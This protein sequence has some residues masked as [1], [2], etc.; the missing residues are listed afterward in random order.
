V[1]VCRLDGW[2][3]AAARD[4]AFETVTALRRGDGSPFAAR[5]VLRRLDDGF[6]GRAFALPDLTPEKAMPAI[7][8]GGRV[9]AAMSVTRAPFLT[10]TL[11]PVA[12]G[13]AWSWARG[14]ARPFPLAI[15]VAAAT[16]AALL[17]VA[18]NMLND[19][20]DWQSGADK[21]N[22]EFFAPFSGGSRSIELGLLSARGVLISGLSA[23]GIASII[24]IVLAI[25]RGWGLVAFGAVGAFA[26]WAYT[27]PPLR[28]VARRGL[29]ELVVGVCF[30]PMLVAGT[31]FA[32]T[33]V[34]DIAAFA[35]GI[36]LGLLTLAILWINEI[37][38][39]P[40]DLAAGKTNLVVVLG[41]KRA[42][43]GYVV[44]ISTA[45]V[46]VGLLAALRVTPVWTL[47]ALLAC[48]LA[49]KAAKVALA[50]HGDR[51]L[52]RANA[53]TIQLNLITG[54]L[55]TIGCIVAGVFG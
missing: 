19:Y 43:V 55:M 21:N 33:G 48:P 34:V 49:I 10:A 22:S 18:A 24:G 15:F 45:L 28:L 38:D 54:I 8:L 2:L 1:A 42:A 47:I 30:G 26:A 50:H 13:A 37:P 14:L 41:P 36:P 51:S 5:L 12:L 3:A 52:V 20:F 7:G 46:C 11:A 35:T 6:E 44:L 17:Q 16:A 4:G 39:A 25:V 53:G 31:V 9:A 23:L 27:A 40:S 29:G 32:L